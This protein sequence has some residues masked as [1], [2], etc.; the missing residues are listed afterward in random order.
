MSAWWPPGHI[1]GYEHSF[2][3]QARD[4]IQAVHDGTAPSPSFEEALGVQ[5]VLE[6]VE[7]SAE[8]GAWTEVK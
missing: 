8:S 4:F 7:R 1:I 2:T 6:A 3:H 5:L